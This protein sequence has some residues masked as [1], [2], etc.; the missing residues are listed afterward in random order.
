MS[1]KFS[2]IKIIKVIKSRSSSYFTSKITTIKIIS[3][4]RWINNRIL[5]I[6]RLKI[7]KDN[8]IKIRWVGTNLK[9]RMISNIRNSSNRW[10]EVNQPKINGLVTN[11]I[12]NNKTTS[13]TIIKIKTLINNNYSSITIATIIINNNSHSRTEVIK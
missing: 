8:I 2:M 6:I 7:I 11:H 10:K 1:D 9:V 4:I 13:K 3:N 5:T 12:N